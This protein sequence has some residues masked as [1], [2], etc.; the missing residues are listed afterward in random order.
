MRKP[1][2]RGVPIDNTLKEI[3]T[4]HNQLSKFDANPSVRQ[5]QDVEICVI[6]DGTT[7]S[8]GVRIGGTLYGVTLT[9]L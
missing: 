2:T 9:E 5:L 4:L 6:D 3:E 8:L 1:L 7:R